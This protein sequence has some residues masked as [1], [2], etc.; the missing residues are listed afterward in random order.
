MNLTSAK[1]RAKCCKL[2][3]IPHL[4]WLGCHLHWASSFA[5]LYL[6][7]SEYPHHSTLDK[8]CVDHLVGFGPLNHRVGEEG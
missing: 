5:R 7:L 6:T 1:N 3:Q 2:A 8:V 4:H